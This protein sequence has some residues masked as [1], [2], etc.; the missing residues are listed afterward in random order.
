MGW[1]G[2]DCRNSKGSSNTRDISEKKEISDFSW[3]LRMRW[4]YLA[5]AGE[6]E[7]KALCGGLFQV[8]ITV[9]YGTG[10]R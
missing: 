8:L 3:E 2:G 5:E 6:L 10:Q 1:R 7:K 9:P 4:W